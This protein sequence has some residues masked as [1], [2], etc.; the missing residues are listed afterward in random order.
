V[1]FVL[2][3]IFPDTLY[4]DYFETNSNNLRKIWNSFR[5]LIDQNF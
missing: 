5:E 2:S 3:R 1:V 4:S